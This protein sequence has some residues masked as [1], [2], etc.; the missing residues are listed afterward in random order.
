[1]E[2][3]PN[4]FSNKLIILA[5]VLYFVLF[6][7]FVFTYLHEAWHTLVGPAIIGG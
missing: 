7:F 2:T 5:L 3:K 1:M 6:V 4:A